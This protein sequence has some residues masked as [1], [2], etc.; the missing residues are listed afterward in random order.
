MKAHKEDEDH[1]YDRAVMQV[2]EATCWIAQALDSECISIDKSHI[3][4]L[5]RS[6]NQPAKMIEILT[7]RMKSERDV[8]KKIFYRWDLI[9][10]AIKYEYK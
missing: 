9:K 4:E 6:I 10:E 2:E 8:D 1:M 7:T 3:I 5:Y